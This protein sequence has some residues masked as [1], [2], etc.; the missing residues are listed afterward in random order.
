M[1]EDRRLASVVRW[2]RRVKAI[3]THQAGHRQNRSSCL[4]LNASAD[5]LRSFAASSGIMPPLI[6]ICRHLR[7][8]EEILPASIRPFESIRKSFNGR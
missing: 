8:T 5:V 2:D 3:F 4:P 7:R 6:Q 1:K